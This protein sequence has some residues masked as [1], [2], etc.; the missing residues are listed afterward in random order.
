M[1]TIKYFAVEMK[2]VAIRFQKAI[3]DGLFEDLDF[4]VSS[5]PEIP[6]VL[7]GKCVTNGVTIDVYYYLTTQHIYIYIDGIYIPLVNEE[8]SAEQAIKA[9]GRLFMKKKPLRIG[10]QTES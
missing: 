9:V 7:T 10:Q 2:T 6:N 5:D 4:E 8:E 1:N 3:A